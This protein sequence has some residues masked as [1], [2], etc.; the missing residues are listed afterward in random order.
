MYIYYIYY[1]ILY[2]I[3]YI[4]IYT[5]IHKTME[6]ELSYLETALYKDVHWFHHKCLMVEVCFHRSVYFGC[7]TIYIFSF[8]TSS[9]LVTRRTSLW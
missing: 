2:Y 3:Y 8:T 7:V 1:Y 4:Y 6:T 9:L 5:T